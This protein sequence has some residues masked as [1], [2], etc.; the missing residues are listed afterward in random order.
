MRSSEHTSNFRV[1]IGTREYASV[2]K[3]D[4][5]LRNIVIVKTEGWQAQWGVAT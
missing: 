3:F 5:V 2:V 4:S 1:G